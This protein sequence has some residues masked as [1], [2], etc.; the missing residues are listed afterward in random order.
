MK[1]P[2]QILADNKFPD[3]RQSPWKKA[4]R[5]FTRNRMALFGLIIVL[6]LILVALMAPI[7]APYDPYEMDIKARFSP[8]TLQHLFGTDN[9]GRDIFSRIL[10]GARISLQVGIVSVVI[11]LV[12]GVLVGAIASFIGGAV[13]NVVMRLMDAFLAFPSI[14]LALLLRFVFGP[15]ITSVMIAIAIIRIPVF[16]RTIRSSVLSERER[17]YVTAALSIGQTKANI[18][19]RHIIP[20][21]LAPLIV[22]V[23]VFFANAI[24][25]EASMSFLGIGTPPPQPS[26]GIMLSD[27]R[28]YMENHLHVVLFPG[29][30]ISSVVLGVNLLGDGLRDM[31]D[32]RLIYQSG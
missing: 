9:F 20:N 23:T 19:F 10:Y 11:G 7:L 24:L 1:S 32:P 13:D 27:G 21:S 28:Q 4:M 5:E 22:M 12:I 3:N 16:A 17:D 26:W 14:M 31:L 29:L 8:P 18:L 30:A 2:K 15:S 6:V 25:I